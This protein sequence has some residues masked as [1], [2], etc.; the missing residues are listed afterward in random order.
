[1]K[2]EIIIILAGIL[3]GFLSEIGGIGSIISLPILISLGIPPIVANG[4]NRIGVLS[5]Y[6]SGYL[7]YHLR[8][9]SVKRPNYTIKLAAPILV[10]VVCGALFANFISN[11][12]TNWII[13][14]FSVIMIILNTNI[15]I[16]KRISYQTVR[17]NLT[18]VKIIILFS[19]GLYAGLVQSGIGYIFFYVFANIIAIDYISSKF[20]KH[21]FSMLATPFALLVF[22]LFGNVDIYT[23]ILVFIGGIIGGWIG[24]ICLEKWSEELNRSVIRITIILSIIY[25]ILFVTHH[26]G[27]EVI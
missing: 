16:N 12:I 22:I 4:T 21:Y 27:H 6:S 25:L 23:G 5:F 17:I 19:M 7:Y 11:S 10:G 20:L 8:N 15:K 24:S 3:S 13:V 2:E 9:K 14:S 26:F 1:M 18:M